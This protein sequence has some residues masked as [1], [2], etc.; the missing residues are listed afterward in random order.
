L[1]SEAKGLK[2]SSRDHQTRVHSDQMVLAMARLE[3]GL[4]ERWTN[5]R[6]TF[7]E[8]TQTRVGKK[9]LAAKKPN[10]KKAER[11]PKLE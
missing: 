10:R 7:S 9:L 8:D 1:L 5:S 6:T 2:T 3:A 11:Q 4:C